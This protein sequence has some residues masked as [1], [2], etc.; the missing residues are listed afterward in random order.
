MGHCWCAKVDK[1]E[2]LWGAVNRLP[3][4]A[5]MTLM[6]VGVEGL[7]CEQAGERLGIPPET[8]RRLLKRAMEYLLEQVSWPPAH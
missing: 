7:S 2:E 8:A 3:P 6:L 4:K 1:E 5:K